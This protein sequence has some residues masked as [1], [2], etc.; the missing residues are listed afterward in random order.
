MTCYDSK[1]PL[2][3]SPKSKD[4]LAFFAAWGQSGRYE[5]VQTNWVGKIIIREINE[6][7]YVRMGGHIGLTFWGPPH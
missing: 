7:M 3:I 6:G 1:Q 4:M 2:L 5:Y